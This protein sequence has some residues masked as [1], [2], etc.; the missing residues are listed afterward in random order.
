MEAE[1]LAL[2]QE[3]DFS[4][5]SLFARA[6]LTVKLVMIMLVIASV[7]AWGI[8]F[9]RLMVTARPEAKRAVSM[10]V[11]G[12]ANRWTGCSTRLALIPAGGPRGYSPVVWWNGG[13]R[14]ATMAR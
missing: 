14:T 8:I 1:T 5:W 6:T 2:A 10:N 3:I 13:V 7:W 11:S 12:Q 4:V 9:Q